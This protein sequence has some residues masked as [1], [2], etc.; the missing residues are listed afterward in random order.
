MS[1]YQEDDDSDEE[2]LLTKWQPPSFDPPKPLKK[3]KAPPILYPTV[4]E[5]EAIRTQARQDAYDVGLSEGFTK[6]RNDGFEQG[7]SQGYETGYKDGYTQAEAET[8]RLHASL[9]TI[10]EAIDG[11]TDAIAEPMIQ[12]SYDIAYRIAANEN[13]TRGP[14]VAAIQEA[15]MRLPRPGTSLYLRIREEDQVTWKKIIDDPGLP[16]SCTLL[17][18]ADVQTGHAFVEVD[19]ARINVGREA[20]IALVRSSLGLP[21]SKEQLRLNSGVIPVA[22][23]VES[24]FEQ[25]HPSSLAVTIDS[26]DRQM[27]DQNHDLNHGPDHSPELNLEMKSDVPKQNKT[28]DSSSDD[29]FT[30]RSDD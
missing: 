20:R 29:E 24:I 14:F 11:M 9:Q 2:K 13:M 7:Q 19:G 12:L 17:I 22:P 1:A 5:V 8:K 26:D 10:L 27:H 28:P 6:G 3:P 21:L 18:D 30:F 15:L 4:E 23:I 25:Q 16:F